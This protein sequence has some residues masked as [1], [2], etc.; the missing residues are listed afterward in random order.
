MTT[1]QL[2]TFDRIAKTGAWVSAAVS[3]GAYGA[4]KM[5]GEFC[6]AL[7]SFQ[8]LF[9][10]PTVAETVCQAVTPVLNS[11]ASIAAPVAL[12]VGCAYVANRYRK[13]PVPLTTRVENGIAAAAN[14]ARK[15]VLDAVNEVKQAVNPTS[16][17]LRYIPY[18]GI[19]GG[20]VT[21]IAS[22]VLDLDLL[23][24]SKE[25][26]R[27][28][29]SDAPLLRAINGV[30]QWEIKNLSLLTPLLPIAAKIVYDAVRSNKSDGILT[31][32]KKATGKNLTK[33]QLITLA[34][35]ATLGLTSGYYAPYL[36]I[37]ANEFD[38]S[39]HMMLKTLMAHLA[40]IHLNEIARGRGWAT[41]GLVAGFAGLSAFTDGVLVHNTTRACH[42]VLEALAGV[43]WGAGIIRLK[44][45]VSQPRE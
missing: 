11:V 6:P 1:A 27:S 3:V 42:T 14:R 7:T 22:R 4:A 26:C 5:L 40:S 45:L 34:F 30:K 31:R 41:K 16:S 44:N 2:N 38:A 33:D 29:F 32:L 15:G 20:V 35:I 23:G 21:G 28:A 19:A 25:L 37:S 39:G 10:T 24:K 9:S 12:G 43:A 13:R 8:R 18:A 36:G 17:P